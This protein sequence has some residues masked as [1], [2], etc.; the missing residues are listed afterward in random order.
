MAREQIE[1][2][3]T[4]SAL[5][6]VQ[7]MA[8]VFYETVSDGNVAATRLM[9]RKL[10]DAAS[11]VT[12]LIRKLSVGIRRHSMGAF[13]PTAWKDMGPADI[14]RDLANLV[15]IDKM[16]IEIKEAKIPGSRSGEQKR[17]SEE[18]ARLKRTL[19]NKV[20]NAKAWIQ[21]YWPDAWTEREES[22]YG[23]WL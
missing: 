5:V 12:R 6:A 22:N 4:E 18:V 10:A 14:L 8:T 17:L 15:E 2:A 3:D 13:P 19:E 21:K 1:F 20:I 7:A 9:Y 16:L 23:E 11:G